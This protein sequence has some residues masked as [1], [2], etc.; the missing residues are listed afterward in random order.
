MRPIKAV[1]IVI[2]CLL[3][4]CTLTASG[5]ARA[6]S[7]DITIN[8]VTPANN[9][10]ITNTT[11]T[12]VIDYQSPNGIDLT[13]V[14]VT[15]DGFEIV[16]NYDDAMVGPNNFTFPLPY[17]LKEGQ[18]NITVTLSDRAG[19]PATQNFTFYVNTNQAVGGLNLPSMQQIAIW[20]LIALGIGLLAFAFVLFYLYKTRNFTLKKHFAKH[21]VPKG[22]FIGV[23]PALVALFFVLFAYAFFQSDPKTAPFANEYI[24]VTA[25]FIALM[26]YAIYTQREKRRAK[27]YERAFSQFLF[28]MADAMRGGIDPSKAMI[29]LSKSDTGILGDHIKIAAAGI[30]M[31]RPFEEMINVMVKPIKSELVK[32]YASLVGESAKVGGEISLVVH[33]A[34]KDM[35]DLIKI[36]E[37]R[38]RD[39]T[40]QA[41]TIYIAFGILNIILYMLVMIY[42]MIGGMQLGSL[43]SGLST[44]QT[45]SS[46][47]VMPLVTLEQRFLD[48][49]MISGL[50]NGLLIGLIIDGKAKYGLLH[51]LLMVLAALIF[52]M[53]MIL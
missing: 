36:N 32:R 9:S 10:T 53:I 52:F 20:A 2:V 15:L 17:A 5:D 46:T 11:P 8:M 30:E 4:A 48:L 27:T 40:S 7:T 1:A 22:V 42:P 33:R 38:A 21:P 44:S 35:D 50:G 13:S 24:I 39:L 12:I 37:E 14:N 26:P 43:T 3:M 23:I 49:A 6:N 34:A 51:G 31:G 18:H 47:P 25:G 28:E 19:N 16:G 29:E 41:T 45:S